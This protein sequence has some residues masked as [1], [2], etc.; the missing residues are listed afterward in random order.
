MSIPIGWW[1]TWHCV[2]NNQRNGSMHVL[3]LLHHLVLWTGLKA[4]PGYTANTA[5]PWWTKMWISYKI[6]DQYLIHPIPVRILHWNKKWVFYIG[7]GLGDKKTEAKHQL[8]SKW[9]NSNSHSPYCW[10]SS[11]IYMPQQQSYNNW[12]WKAHRFFQGIGGA[13]LG[14]L[15][16]DG[17]RC[18]VR[19][20]SCFKRLFDSP[21]SDLVYI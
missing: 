19:G 13:F 20:Y 5:L 3:D 4:Y 6:F 21:W 11:N 15:A 2:Y 1:V 9:S 8:K 16:D 12:D 10:I 18:R 14:Y 17:N 7:I